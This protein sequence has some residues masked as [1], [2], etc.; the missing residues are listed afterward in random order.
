MGIRKLSLVQGSRTKSAQDTDLLKKNYADNPQKKQAFNEVFPYATI[1]VAT[2]A[3]SAIEDQVST[4]LELSMTG[5]L[6]AA[7][8][9]KKAQADA[10]KALKEFK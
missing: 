6:P 4:A 3:R 7:D 1:D 10:T 2:A 5:E 8:A 9:M